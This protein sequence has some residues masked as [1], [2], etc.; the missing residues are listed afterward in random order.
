MYLLKDVITKT[1][2]H[3]FTKTLKHVFAKTLKH[4]F[5]K[6]RKFNSHSN[7]K[8]THSFMKTLMNCLILFFSTFALS[9]E[10]PLNDLLIP[11]TVQKTPNTE[12]YF[13]EIIP[14][15]PLLEIELIVYNRWGV[16]VIKTNQ[17]VVVWPKD[18]R[19]DGTYMYILKGKWV[20]GDPIEKTG[21]INFVK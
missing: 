8:N 10:N 16:Q 19:V 5:S 7:K 9:Q 17:L 6:T 18:K 13:F 3:V 1:L 12:R 21:Y 2:K 20:N 15:R 4:V 11:T 14:N